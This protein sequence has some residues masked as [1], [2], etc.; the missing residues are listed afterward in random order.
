MSFWKELG[1]SE[2]VHEPD[3]LDF[4][5]KLQQSGARSID[6]F[7][8]SNRE[9][10]IRIGK[11]AI[12]SILLRSERVAMLY[13]PIDGDDWYGY[14]WNHMKT[15]CTAK[16]FTENRVSIVNFNYDRSF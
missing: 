9:P 10:Y 1:H 4:A 3:V 6:A 14:L 8:E 2:D 16:T 11:R 7:L 15:G 13:Q 5:K 12:A